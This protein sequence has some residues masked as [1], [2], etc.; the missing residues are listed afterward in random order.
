[1]PKVLIKVNVPNNYIGEIEKDVKLIL[2]IE[3]FRR[4]IISLGRAA[5]IAEVPIQDFIYELM[6]RKISP[7]KYDDEELIEELED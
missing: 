4:G 6:L 7:F 5:E 1:M 3:L 2:A